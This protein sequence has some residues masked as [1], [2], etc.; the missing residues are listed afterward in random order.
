MCW[1]FW[2]NSLCNIN[3]IRKAVVIMNDHPHTD[4]RKRTTTAICIICSYIVVY[5]LLTLFMNVISN[6][7]VIFLI[8][9]AF[10][11]FFTYRSSKGTLSDK[12][13]FLPLPFFIVVVIM[14]SAIIGCFTAPFHIG[15]WIAE[16]INKRTP[17]SPKK[18]VDI[19]SLS[20]EEMTDKLIAEIAKDMQ[21]EKR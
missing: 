19:A 4:S 8:F 14:L 21:N 11:I 18:T 7:S 2:I 6:N 9:L 5:G 17:T 10:C 13:S 12:L 1:A 15:K 3:V 16:F 20:D